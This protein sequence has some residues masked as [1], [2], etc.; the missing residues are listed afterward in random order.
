V[1]GDIGKH[2]PEMTL[3]QHWPEKLPFGQKYEKRKM[4]IIFI[5]QE[6]NDFKF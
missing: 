2:R 5:T 3:Q 6:K 1:W 4:E